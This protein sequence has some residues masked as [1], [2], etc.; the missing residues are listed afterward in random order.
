MKEEFDYGKFNPFYDYVKND[1]VVTKVNSGVLNSNIYGKL[2][3]SHRG[4]HLSSENDVESI[5]AR[6][7]DERK[8]L[9]II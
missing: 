9:G 1:Q 2:V 5:E 3:V 8:K 7:N 4:L 6:L